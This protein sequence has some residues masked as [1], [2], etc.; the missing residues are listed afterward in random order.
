MKFSAEEEGPE[1]WLSQ[2][3]L[4]EVLDLLKASVERSCAVLEESPAWLG[5]GVRKKLYRTGH[6]I[7][8]CTEIL[9]HRLRKLKPSWRVIIRGGQIRIYYGYR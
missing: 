8:V 6:Y 1:T 9:I 7:G 3:H 5:S 2:A 4:V